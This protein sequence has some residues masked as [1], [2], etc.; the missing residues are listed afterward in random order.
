MTN[1]ISLLKA[2]YCRAIVKTASFA[3]GEEAPSL[4]HAITTERVTIDVGPEVEQA[5]RAALAA[6]SVLAERL[7]LAP[8]R[9]FPLQDT[10]R[11]RLGRAVAS[12]DDVRS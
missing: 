5:E 7:S 3:N 12:G 4:V 11:D 2:R 10:A 9:V 1:D 8:N 6:V